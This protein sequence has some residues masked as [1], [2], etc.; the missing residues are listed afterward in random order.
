MAKKNETRTYEQSLAMLEDVLSKLED[1]STG[2]DEGI[3]LYE[4]GL[5]IARE[6]LALLN[7]SKGKV[8]V[9]QEKLDKLVETEFVTDHDDL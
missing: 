2:I 7:E 8:T 6:C 4:Q 9:L 3:A 5:E 1:K